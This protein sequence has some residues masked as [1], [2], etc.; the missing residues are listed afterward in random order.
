MDQDP[1]PDELAPR[2]DPPGPEGAI[3]PGVTAQGPPREPVQP[4]LDD[5]NVRAHEVG[6]D[7]AG[8]TEPS[9]SPR[10]L[11]AIAGFRIVREVG[12]GGMGVVY[13]A[14]ELALG[15]RVALKVLPSGRSTT[16]RARFQREARAAARLHHTHIVPVFGVGE[17]GGMHYYAMQFIPGEGLDLVLLGLE[18]FRRERALPAAAG[19]ETT[20]GQD[21]STTLVC[22]LCTGQFP[23]GAAAEEAAQVPD[24]V[25]P[26]VPLAPLPPER[27]VPA[28]E[29]G[30]RSDLILLPE[31]QYLRR[32]ARIGVQVAEALEYAHQQGI[33][34]RDIKPSNLMLDT[35]G[36]TWVTDF[37]L[38]KDQ[39]SDALTR[40]GDIVGTLRYMA[41]E[42]FQGQCDPRS[43]VYGLGLTLYELVAMRPAYEAVDRPALMERVL[44][45]EPPRLKAVA[46]T[47]PR[48]LETIIQKAIARDPAQRYA[49]AAALAEDLRRFLEDRPIRARRVSRTERLLRWCRRNRA[50]AALS[51]TVSLLLVLIAASSF[52]TALW[53]NRE[54]GR[55]RAAY[56][57]NRR[58]LYAA[59]IH[60][61]HRAWE[62]AQIARAEEILGY[63]PCTAGGPDEPDLRGWEWHYLRRLCHSEALMLKGSAPQLSVVAFSPDGSFLAAAGLD[64]TVG[65]C[66]LRADDP[67]WTTLSGHSGWVNRVIF[68]PDGRALASAGEDGTVRLWEAKT[69]RALRTLAVRNGTA[70]AVTF[71][72]DGRLIVG[73][74]S[75]GVISVWSRDDG[76]L[77]RTFPA[78]NAMILCL[79]SS[80]DG[81]RLASC[82]Q[83]GKAKV[84]D[85]D[86]GR[87]LRTF[88]GHTAQV[89]GVAFS[90]DGHTLATSSED[91]RA[92]LWDA[93]TGARRALLKGHEAWVLNSAFSPDG[94]RI[95]SASEDG[96]V[97]VWDAKTGAEQLRLRGHVGRVG[98]V[99]FHPAGRYLA[100][101]GMDGTVRLW[102][103]ARG[104]QEFRVLRGHGYPVTRVAFGPGGRTLASASRDFTLRIWDVASGRGVL[105]L[106]GHR[107][108]VRGLAYS[109]DGHRLASSSLDGTVRLWD[110]ETGRLLQSIPGHQGYILSVA[111]DRNGHRLASAGADGTVRIWN[112][113][114]QPVTVLR[115]HTALVSDLAYSP[116]GRRLASA[117]QDGTV[118]LWEMASGGEPRV[119]RGTSA[120]LSAVRFS[121]DGRLIAAAGVDG[122]V[123][124]WGADSG[125]VVRA[126]RHHESAVSSLAFS[127]DGRR[128]VTIGGARMV[129]LWDTATGLEVLSLKSESSH[130]DVTFDPAGVRIAVA[131]VDHAV[132]LYEAD[133]RDD[134]RP[135]RL[136]LAEPFVGPL[137]AETASGLDPSPLDSDPMARARD[138]VE[139][140]QWDAAESAFDA[141]VRARPR[142][143][144]IWLERGRFHAMR[145]KPEQAAADLAQAIRLQPEELSTRYVHVLSL[146]A[147]GDQAGLRRACADLL[148][149][150]GS[151][152]DP[153]TANNIAWDCVLGPDA[154]ADPEAPVHLAEHA[155]HAAPPAEKAIFLNTL[156][157]AL[158]RAGRYEEAIRR[159]EEGVQMRGGESLPHDWAFLAMAHHQLGH[160]VQAHRWLD[161]FRTDR[162]SHDAD[163]FWDEWEIHLLRDEAEALILYDPIFPADPFAR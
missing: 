20:P 2:P 131:G 144:S 44:H 69:G 91:T 115:G 49:T 70:R 58:T 10:R 37:G 118:R 15:R 129:K 33:L 107:G 106:H 31:V 162:A 148:A 11:P 43:D 66:D 45:Q 102:D 55:T 127:P 26:H 9:A 155:V 130:Y 122:V 112:E 28:P 114:G 135:R 103:L 137:G 48:D 24:H 89:S 5:G 141:A 138:R 153:Q 81:R 92:R 39:D 25:E 145:G 96:T 100:S 67:A 40:T 99:A 68:S 86:S 80:P 142:A 158:Y 32:V 156:G 35:Q 75:E 47:V 105:I 149:H 22:G 113:L 50:L 124:L 71:S 76:R 30:P 134:L 160:P 93:D 147:A 57:E 78:H 133:P 110:A 154:V 139:R 126:A 38:A 85:V 152:T 132:T 52:A 63:P 7:L 59:Q 94:R 29:P 97:R 163:A 56:L 36:Q 121:P 54:R 90:P 125:E 111:F 4:E 12:Q 6:Q 46:P 140:Q 19:S 27:S 42:R 34:H 53:M 104:R 87:L 98:S 8:G 119:L 143:A 136:P 17:S 77:L 159:L 128:L 65:L 74:G 23:P 18:R 1:A 123:T 21:L 79:S 108:E 157:A 64:G 73:A 101:S 62:D 60:L 120:A 3:L 117:S 82:G 116:D 83:D 72:P 95:A 88:A 13:E 41:P 51:G 146:R 151:A 61:A 161:R 14:I 150:F 109:P 16:A 84:W